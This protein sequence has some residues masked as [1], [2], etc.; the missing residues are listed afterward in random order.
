MAA[1]IGLRETKLC[2]EESFRRLW[3]HATEH[4]LFECIDDTG[5]AQGCAVAAVTTRYQCD[6]GGGFL[7]LDY[8]AVTDPYYQHWV[9]TE[10]GSGKWHHVCRRSLS[11]CQRKVGKDQV[12]HIQRMAFISPEDVDACLKLWKTKRLDQRPPG[13]KRPA[14]TPVVDPRR[15][16]EDA[17]QTGFK[18]KSRQ[19]RQGTPPW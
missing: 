2:S 4:I 6:V 7:K 8:A 14:M 3:D 12:V 13:S 19:A 1:G 17:L 16:Q 10:G 5:K 9:E 15:R 11:T 18:V